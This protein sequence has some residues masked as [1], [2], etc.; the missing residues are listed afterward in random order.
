VFKGSRQISKSSDF[1]VYTNHW[2]LEQS[3]LLLLKIKIMGKYGGKIEH[4]FP[5]MTRAFG[6]II[7]F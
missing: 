6:I 4:Q 5:E 7:L 1:L 3:R 2:I